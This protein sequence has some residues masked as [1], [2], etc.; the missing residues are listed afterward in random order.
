MILPPSS[1]VAGCAASL[2]QGS[3][4][5]GRSE[6][7]DGLGASLAVSPGDPLSGANRVDGLLIGVP[8]EDVGGV[9][10]TGRVL[11]WS[12]SN[13]NVPTSSFG[14]VAGDRKNGRF[15]EALPTP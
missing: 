4:L 3:T 8:G 10:D 11:A 9:H 7:G 13:P 12:A 15:G 2:T 6:A 5:P 1:G 14:S